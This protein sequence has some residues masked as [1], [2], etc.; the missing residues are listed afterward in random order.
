[1]ISSPV[2]LDVI[3]PCLHVSQPLGSVVDQQ[4]LDQVLGVLLHVLRPLELA[5]EDL[6]VDAE[7]VVVEEGR[8]AGKHL[9]DQDP[10]CP[11]VHCLVVALQ[12]MLL[13]FGPNVFTRKLLFKSKTFF[14]KGESCTYE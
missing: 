6:L 2:F 4:P 7:G 14:P 5:G 3:C 11:P 8:V 10:K 12:C 9:V 13:Q 1:M